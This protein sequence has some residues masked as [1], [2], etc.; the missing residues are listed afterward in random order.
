MFET[1]VLVDEPRKNV[2]IKA[3]KENLDNLNFLADKT[4]DYVNKKQLKAFVLL[5]RTA[6]CRNWWSRFLN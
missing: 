6:K 2:A 4:M 5:I 3:E 1:A